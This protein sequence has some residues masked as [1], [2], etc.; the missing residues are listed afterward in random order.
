MFG[1]FKNGLT[2]AKPNSDGDAL[3]SQ[4]LCQEGSSLQADGDLRGAQDC[5]RQAVLLDP[6][7]ADAHFLLGSVLEKLSTLEEAALHF[8]RALALKPDFELACLGACRALFHLGQLEPARELLAVGLALNPE[9]PEFH[10]FEGNQYFT[11]GA[12]DSALECYRRAIELGADH[13]HLHGYIGAI[14]LKRNILGEA[15]VHLQRAVELGPRNAEAHLDLGVVHIRLGNVQDAIDSNATAI[16][17]N[18]DQLQAYSCLLFALS[19]SVDSTPLQ[20]QRIAQ[21]YAARARAAVT[22]SPPLAPRPHSSATARPLRVGWVSGDLRVHVNMA[23]LQHVLTGL[24]RQPI[25][26]IAFSN[27]PYDDDVTHELRRLMAQWHDIS[28]LSDRDAAALI[29]SCEVDI[30]VDLAGHTAHNRLPVFAWRPAPVQVSWL[31]YFASTGLDE[32]DYLIADPISVPAHWHS[33]FSERICYL[34]DTRLCMTPPQQSSATVLSNPPVCTTGYVTF[35]SFQALAK[36]N[37]TVLATWQKVLRKVPKSRLRLQ[38]RYLDVPG[39]REALLHRIEQA[40]IPLDRVDLINGTSVVEYLAAHKEVDI[41]LDTFPFPGGTTTA[42]ALWMG[43]PTI[44][45][46]GNSLLGQQGASMLHNAGFPQ[47]IAKDRK[48]YVDRAVRL[49]SDTT[50]LARLRKEMR[51]QVMASALFDSDKFTAQLLAA[52]QSMHQAR[53]EA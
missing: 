31:G 19:Y 44:T 11:Y 32:M 14:L 48:D 9:N 15:R 52:L 40:G 30:L 38:I 51:Q 18:P 4:A 7:N 53:R 50:E 25:T 45:L 41:L 6:T 24:S 26:L 21:D 37:D 47:W 13:S 8:Q 33:H 3:R 49:A 36:I 29:Q 39:V 16:A 27:N 5:F 23:F 22:A 42:E 2:R 28:D 10:F 12:L 17:L 34:P 1:W 20:Y 46:Q 35:G 43:V